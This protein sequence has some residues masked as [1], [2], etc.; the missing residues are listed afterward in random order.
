MVNN[1]FRAYPI[2]SLGIGNPVISSIGSDHS[3]TNELSGRGYMKMSATMVA[4][5]LNVPGVS[6]VIELFDFDNATGELSN[7]RTADLNS[8][9]GQVYGIEFAN[10]KIFATLIL[11]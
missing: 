1:S 11:E 4:V 7:F 5:A 6:N 3:I 2:T 10:N 9:T 8:A